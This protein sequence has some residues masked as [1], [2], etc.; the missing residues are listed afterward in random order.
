MI[1]GELSCSS[2]S[3]YLQFFDP[4]ALPVDLAPPAKAPL[5]DVLNGRSGIIR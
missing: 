5:E 2:E 3:E 1:G 4:A